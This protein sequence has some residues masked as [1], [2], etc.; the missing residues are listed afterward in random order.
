MG[1]KM[2]GEFTNPPKWDTKA[3]LTTTAILIGGERAMLQGD[4]G[5]KII[6]AENPQADG[7][8]SARKATLPFAEVN[9]CDFPVLVLKGIYHWVFYYYFQGA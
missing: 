4:N 9:I 3:V 7:K 2:G 5:A 8:L 6:E 1:S